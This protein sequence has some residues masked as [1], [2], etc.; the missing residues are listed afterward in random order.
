MTPQLWAAWL[1]SLLLVSFA[2]EEPEKVNCNQGVSGTVYDY[3]AKTLDG[4]DTQFSKYSG[5]NIL[6]VNVA[7][8]CDYTVQYPELN[9]LQEELKND[10]TVLGF[11]C[12]QFGKQ[13][14][15]RNS[16]ILSGIQ[17]VRPGGGFVPSFQLFEKGDVNGKNEQQVFTF[18]KNACPPTSEL[19]GSPDYLFWD[20]MKVHD[21]RW[22]FEKFFVNSS[23][24]P[25]MRWS[26]KIPVNKVKEDIISYLGQS[27]AQ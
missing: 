6:F 15:G 2:Q 19:L 14:P 13:E 21:I 11:P 5:M 16:E 23:G 26:H 17:Y 8:Y 20:P 4:E 27:S 22:N 10:V 3:K 25:V 24:T 12:N 9:S 1:L 18:L 7:T